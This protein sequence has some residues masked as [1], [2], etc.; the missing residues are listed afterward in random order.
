MEEEEK[1]EDE[2]RHEK[3]RKMYNGMENVVKRGSV[4]GIEGWET[5]REGRRK[6]KRRERRKRYCIGKRRMKKEKR[7]KMWMIYI[8]ANTQIYTIHLEASNQVVS[9]KGR[10]AWYYVSCRCKSHTQRPR[11]GSP[12][13]S[14]GKG[15]V[16]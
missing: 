4:V 1:Q 6:D 14:M 16:G 8:S 15:R 3:R 7:R 10:H 2:E 12:N 9:T 5:R 11:E 13:T